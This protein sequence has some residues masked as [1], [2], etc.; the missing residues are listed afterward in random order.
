MTDGALPRW[1]VETGGGFLGR[2]P[3]NGRRGVQGLFG[4]EALLD[5]VLAG[6]GAVPSDAPG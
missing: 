5:Q 4:G 3:R 1:P 6:A 2:E